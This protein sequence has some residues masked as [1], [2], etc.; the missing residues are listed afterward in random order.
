MADEL[1]NGT[2]QGYFA[3]CPKYK[4]TMET[5]IQGDALD[6]K[7]NLMLYTEQ[8]KIEEEI[9]KC[10]LLPHYFATKY[11]MV[12][13]HLGE[14]IKFKTNMSEEEFNKMFKRLKYMSNEKRN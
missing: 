1:P 2:R 9:I 10:N 7:C 11:L 8:D 12:V 3:T 13:N 14:K 4:K 5:N 6:H